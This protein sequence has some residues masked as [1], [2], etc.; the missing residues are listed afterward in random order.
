MS[1]HDEEPSEARLLLRGLPRRKMALLFLVLVLH[2][3]V[4]TFKHGW[5]VGEQRRPPCRLVALG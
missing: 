3:G 1:V 5:L 2:L 4:L